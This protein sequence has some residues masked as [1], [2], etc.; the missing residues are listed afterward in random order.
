MSAAVLAASFAALYA[1]H[2]VA[3]HVVQTDFQAS[4]KAERG[5]TGVIAMAGHVGSYGLTQTLACTLLLV[6][7]VPLSPLG[8]IVGLA[9]S[10]ATHA[11][12]DRRWPVQWILRHTGSDRFAALASGGMNG[13][14]LA[15][16]AL[17]V[18]CLFVAAVLMGALS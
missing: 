14:Y 10:A 16:Q 7:G 12:I 1:S 2:M 11:F 15:D 8:L 3:D 6:A 4:F 18:G 13:P 9:V 17:H 5:R